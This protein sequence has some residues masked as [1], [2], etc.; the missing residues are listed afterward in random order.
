VN[1]LSVDWDYFFPCMDN[2]DWCHNKRSFMLDIIWHARVGDFDLLTKQKAI[3]TL[4]PTG[5]QD[6]WSKMRFAFPV[7]LFI[8][9]THADLYHILSGCGPVAIWNF[10]AHH[11]LGY[12]NSERNL[13]CGSWANHLLKEGRICEYHVVYPQWRKEFPETKSEYMSKNHTIKRVEIHHEIPKLPLFNA[14]FICRSS[15][16]T[17][18]WRDNHWLKF[19]HWWRDYREF[20]WKEKRFSEFVLKARELTLKKAIAERAQRK[21]DF[22][23]LRKLNTEVQSEKIEY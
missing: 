3:E 13:D 20:A 22:E 12:G 2:Y 14:V 19:I 10:D 18:P 21:K 9:E 5:Y 15:A 23:L 16:W 11:D 8:A 7:Q 4:I 17:P 6:F 1:I